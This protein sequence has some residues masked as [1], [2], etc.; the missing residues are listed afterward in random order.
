MTLSVHCRSLTVGWPR[1]TEPVLLEGVNLDI[2]FDEINQCLPIV[3]QTGLGKS[4]LLY[5]LGGMARPLDGSVEWH[6]SPQTA[7][8]VVRWEGGRRR[9]FSAV[10][11]PRA[12]DF[13]FVLQDAEMIPCL[14]VE[15]NL[16]HSLALRNLRSDRADMKRR[17]R[18]AVALMRADREDID[19]LLQKYP[20]NLSGGTRK[21][22]ALALA[23]AHDPTVLFADEPTSNLDRVTSVQVLRSIRRWLDERS[24]SAPRAF[25][26]V[27]HNI[28]ILEE[29]LGAGVVYEVARL[30]DSQRRSVQ[31][32]SVCEAATA[33]AAAG[34]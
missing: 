33:T 29:G 23:I 22:M 32:R 7:D 12:H 15:Q 10:S 30:G 4:T 19:E 3:G 6:L 16:W 34:K 8:S 14:T 20:A 9:Q 18:N 1:A 27:T 26:C 21:R 28:D 5:A 13:G 2:D 17:I 25:V 11:L 24:A 31:R